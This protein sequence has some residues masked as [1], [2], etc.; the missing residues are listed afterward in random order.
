M[1]CL[2]HFYR[3]IRVEGDICEAQLVQQFRDT[4]S[5]RNMPATCQRGLGKW[6]VMPDKG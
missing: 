3:S 5:A 6:T 4:E 2:Y 1:N